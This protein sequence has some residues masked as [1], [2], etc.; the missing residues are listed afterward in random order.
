MAG[1]GSASTG[2]D[3]TAFLGSQLPHRVRLKLIC[4]P[5][6]ALY[7]LPN[8]L[9]WPQQR[10]FSPTPPSYQAPNTP[11]NPLICLCADVSNLFASLPSSVCFS[12]DISPILQDLA[13]RPPK[14]NLLFFSRRHNLPFSHSTWLMPCSFTALVTEPCL[15][16]A[17][18]E[19]LG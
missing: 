1:P 15:G 8:H 11:V 6:K 14:P 16:W 3:E 13:Q 10:N 7:D 5:A 17:L 12:F 4:M 2:L 9:L 19:S 18:A